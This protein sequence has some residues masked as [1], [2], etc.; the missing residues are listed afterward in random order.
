MKQHIFSY[1]GIIT[2]IIVLDVFWLFFTFDKIYQRYLSH[3]FA[4]K[5]LWWAAALFYLLY[6]FG[7]YFVVVRPMAN[8]SVS[9][10]FVTGMIF[11]LVTYGTYDL[12]NQATIKDWPIIITIV[13][14]AWGSL[15][16][17]ISSLIGALVMRKF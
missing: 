16:A 13:D 1:I 12:T 7:L 6:A 14:L 5:P 4:P 17:G 9:M 2:S 15:L 8:Q 10:I 3:V 11:G